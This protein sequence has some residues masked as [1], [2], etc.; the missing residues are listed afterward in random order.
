[1]RE[2]LNSVTLFN[3]I[4][5]IR[6]EKM[7]P[8]LVV[9]GDDDLLAMKRHLTEALILLKGI[10]GKSGVISAARSAQTRGVGDVLFMV[11]AD[12]D[13]LIDD[14]RCLPPSVATSTH[15]DLFMDTILVAPSVIERVVE[16]HVRH[17]ERRG[18]GSVVAST[19]V[20]LS[21]A[22][23]ASI[24][25]LRIVN[26]R[27]SYGLRLENFPF[28]KVSS[29]EP[30]VRE[31]AALAISRSNSTVTVEELALKIDGQAS[32]LPY[33]TARLVGDHDFFRALSRVLSLHGVTGVGAEALFSAFLGAI[34]C[35][36]IMMT[37][38]YA[39]ID[40]WARERGAVG[41]ACPCAV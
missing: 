4:A 7:T 41:F 31:I 19:I 15:H 14:A 40:S 26:E 10:G 20:T 23:A 6:S 21:L 29:L 27:D 16:V 17:S 1:M 12:Y 38:W 13:D 2:A 37:P 24:A 22:L 8:I 36:H 11:D 3:T 35:R 30:S 18:G 5:M 28:G 34:D 9:E 33:P 25:P 32:L 39:T